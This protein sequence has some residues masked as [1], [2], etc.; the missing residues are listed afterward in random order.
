MPVLLALDI[1]GKTLSMTI[2]A[3]MVIVVAGAGL[4]QMLN[5]GFVLFALM[6]AGWAV[7]AALLALSLWFQTGTPS[8][9]LELATLFFALMGP[10]LLLFTARYLRIRSPW[11]AAAASALTVAIACLTPSLFAARFISDPFIDGHGI[12][13][14]QLSAGGIA[15]SAVPAASI[16]GALALLWVRRG[17]DTDVLVTV[18][19]AFLL[20]GYAVGGIWQ[21]PFPV[22]AITNTASVAVLGWAVVRRQLFNPLRSLTADL[23]ERA[24]RQELISQV[25]RRAATLLDL[26]ELLAEAARLIQATFEY[27]AVAIFL[28]DGEEIVLRASSHPVVRQH[29]GKIRLT[30]GTEGICGWVAAHG[31]PQV[32]DDVSREPRYVSLIAGVNTRS[33]LVVPIIR[34]DRVIGVLDIQSA[35]LAAFDQKDMVTQQTI[36]DQL[37]SSIENARLYQETRRRA[38]RLALV[39]RISSAVGSVLDLDAL[40]QI[41][42]REVAPIFEADAFFIAL[43]DERADMLDFRIQVDEG[44]SE[45]RLREPL[46]N[47]FTSRVVT[48]RRPLLVNDVALG[49]PEGTRVEAW[50]TGK[51]PTS[52]IGVPMLIGERITGVMSVQTYRSHA[53][54]A[55]DLLLAGIIADQVAVAIENARLYEDLLGELDVRLRTEKV[56]RE[57]EEKFR[58]LAEQSPNMIFIYGS[59][60]IVYANRQCE[61]S[62]GYSREEL[63]AEGFD[64]RTFAAPGYQAILTDNLRRHAQ[65]EEITPYEYVLV[66]RAGRRIDAILTTK[67]IRY[68]GDTAILG[69][70]TDIT[71][72]TRTER[73]LQSLNAAALAM[74]QALLPTEIFPSASRVL[75]ALGLDSA[76]FITDARDAGRRLRAHCTGSGATGEVRLLT[77]AAGSALLGVEEVPDAAYAIERRGALF[78]TQGATAA[79]RLLAQAPPPGSGTPDAPRGVIVAPLLVADTLFGLLV[80]SGPDLDPQDL[81]IF[82]AF[83]HQAAAAWRKTRLMQ[84]LERSLAE[85]RQAQE[86]L[87]H[88]Q[89]MEAIGRLAGGIAHD[90]NNMLTVISGYT[91]MLSDSLDGNQSALADLNQIRT[92]IKRASVL[93]GRLLTFSRKQILQP[94]VLD[95]NRVVASS[96]SL[97]RPLIGEDIDLVVRPFPEDLSVRADMFQMEQI[98]MNLAVNARDAMPDGGTL[99]VETGAAEVGPA[100]TVSRHGKNG[101]PAPEVPSDLPHGRW[102]V[103]TVRDDGTGMSEEVRAR[104]FEPFFT[105]KA[106]GK[107]SGLGLST[108]YGL[109]TQFGGRVRVESATGLG[110]TFTICI[111]RVAPTAPS[112]ALDERPRALPR[113]SGTVLL[114]EDE[115]GVRELSRRVLERGGYQV[116]SVASAREALLMAEG[117]VVLDIVVTDVVM[118]GGMSGV[119]MGERLSRSRPALPVLYMSGYSDDFRFRARRGSEALPFLR[120]PFQ[121]DD[122][123]LRV[124]ELVRKAEKSHRG[125]DGAP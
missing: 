41:V 100:G 60:R 51:V 62:M 115:P 113:G 5:R 99:L 121:A 29:L 39:N 12:V 46:G 65:G 20:C 70:I 9:L 31:V 42:H 59:G 38:E 94:A 84:D 13:V 98:L 36:A 1:A 102:A 14:H 78:T 4:R 114:V 17:R 64:F 7:T 27:F 26:D 77:E 24:Y 112:T 21:P 80:V 43:Y 25:S 52:W 33:E 81:Q 106:V 66:T 8:L 44:T 76:V 67:L 119:E 55:D 105:T 86:Q 107:G 79:A 103:L 123:L 50:G 85:L 118:P 16:A 68:E 30:I 92:T 96:A 69:I 89:K 88:A 75:A 40:L 10:S 11:P 49:A 61:I 101:T 108:V 93:T 34:S 19:V 125:S 3:A 87:L 2:A 48:T 23:R 83:A 63:L 54:D 97:L 104:I 58:N 37:S 116:I 45:P 35:R 110:S 117:S 74:E 71:T 47:G 124:N 22:M 32:V 73:L 109:V 28:V 91:S 18:S 57:S 82:T 90:F 122:L 6:E 95:L 15:L 120:K 72:R 56:L 111:P 53:Y